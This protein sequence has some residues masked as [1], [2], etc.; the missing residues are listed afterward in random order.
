[1]SEGQTHQ[2]LGTL[3]LHEHT[4]AGYAEAQ[5]QYEA[6]LTCFL[7][8]GNRI[9]AHYAADARQNLRVLER[10]RE[11]M[12][13][14]REQVAAAWR[15]KEDEKR[16]DEWR[17]CCE[18]VLKFEQ[19]VDETPFVEFEKTSETCHG[20]NSV[21]YAQ[22]LHLYAEYLYSLFS[23]SEDREK[24]TKAKERL[25][26][27][28]TIYRAKSDELALASALEL[29]GSVLSAIHD[30]SNDG[31]MA[32][33]EGDVQMEVRSYVE[34]SR[35]FAR[36]LD[37]HRAAYCTNVGNL[38]ITC[39]RIGRHEFA[40]R[41]KLHLDRIREE[42]GTPEEVELEEWREESVDDS[43]SIS[44]D[45][46]DDLFA[47]ESETPAQG[48]LAGTDSEPESVSDGEM[49]VVAEV[50][51]KVHEDSVE[52]KEEEL[53][54]QVAET[55]GNPVLAAKAYLKL[56]RFLQTSGRF[57][58][59]CDAYRHVQSEIGGNIAW[60]E[61]YHASC[62]YLGQSL[63]EIGQIQ[64]SVKI[65]NKDVDVIVFRRSRTPRGENRD[66]YDTEF[67]RSCEELGNSW[68]QSSFPRFSHF[69]DFTTIAPTVRH[70]RKLA[71][72][73]SGR[74]AQPSGWTAV[75]S[76]ESG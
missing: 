30:K 26:S 4:P 56:G 10:T 18:E 48:D 11:E 63:R 69:S 42:A 35:V 76:R 70:W 66:Y 67:C 13:K 44:T 40:K 59:A 7:P 1:M 45:S 47:T 72:V 57:T 17:G 29:Y 27:A 32:M 54:A 41:L 22:S 20:K 74:Y 3:R 65:L 46:S 53:R 5:R 24:L 19:F 2:S 15:E 51:G 71:T 6:A 33:M 31:V 16:L 28:M 75:R 14:Y 49:A 12:Q 38:M 52:K 61:V 50:A 21:E 62:R 64:E 9:D 37:T 60:E 58:E 34:A 23:A 73:T 8:A 55:A 43:P 36:H 39:N 68:F 25:E